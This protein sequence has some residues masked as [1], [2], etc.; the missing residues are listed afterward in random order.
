MCVV[1]VKVFLVFLLFWGFVALKTRFFRIEVISSFFSQSAAGA[2]AQPC[3][4]RF[5]IVLCWYICI[6]LFYG[7]S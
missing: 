3:I 4:A 2:A 6:L 7:G 5:Y 1:F